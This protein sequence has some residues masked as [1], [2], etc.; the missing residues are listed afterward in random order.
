MDARDAGCLNCT[1]SSNTRSVIYRGKARPFE[2]ADESED[3]AAQR[4]VDVSL[5]L[6]A[7]LC[8]EGQLSSCSSLQLRPGRWVVYMVALP[9]CCLSCN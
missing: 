4:V 5:S 1:A 7:A 6:K 8:G 3:A 9:N 2:S